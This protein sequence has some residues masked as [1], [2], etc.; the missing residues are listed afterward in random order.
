LECQSLL[1]QREDSVSGEERQKTRILL[2]D[3]HYIVRQGI[4]RIFEAEPDLEVVGEASDGK[5]AVRLVRQL[6]PDLVLMEAQ[7]SKQDS[8]ETTKQLKAEHPEGRVLILTASEEDEYIIGLIAAGASGYLLKSASAEELVQA[9]RSVRAGD[10]VC[11]EGLAHKLFKRASRLPI[12]VNPAEHLTCRELEVLKLTANGMTN[13]AIASSLGIGERTVRQHLMNIYG[14][15]GVTSRTEAVS[16]AL[17][18][19]WI[20]FD[21]D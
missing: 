5:E 6:R 21:S 7:I 13:Q 8:V 10:F 20:A 9:I 17:K 3:G 16:K 18:E 19:G 15:M 12:S 2:A 11:G 14:K 1:E 4:R